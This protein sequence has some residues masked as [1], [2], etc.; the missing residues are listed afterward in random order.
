MPHFAQ[1]LC[2]DL[3]DALASNLE[4]PTYLFQRSAVAVDEAESLLKD[5]PFAVGE[6]FQDILDLFLEHNDRSHVAR[7]FGAPILDEIA[8]I[9][10]LALAYG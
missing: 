5:L 8:K 7:V 4:L 3:A 10:F 6:R 9:G 1:S 2:L